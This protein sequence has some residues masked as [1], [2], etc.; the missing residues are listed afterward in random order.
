MDVADDNCD[1]LDPSYLDKL[2]SELGKDN[3]MR[4]VEIVPPHAVDRAA[5]LFHRDGFVAVGNALT[6][7]QLKGARQECEEVANGIFERDPKRIGNRGPYRWSVGASQKTGHLLHIPEVAELVDLPTLTPILKAIFGNDRY[8]CRGARG[9]VNLPGAPYQPLHSDVWKEFLP[10]PSITEWKDS[11][12]LNVRDLP[13]FYVVV[14]FVVHNLTNL[15]APIRQIPMSQ[16]SQ[17]PIP[18]LEDEPLWM[19]RS[20]VCP[21]PAGTAIIRDPRAWHGGTPNLSN[22]M[23]C[24]LNVE[25][26]AYWYRFHTS[27]QMTKSMPRE[28]YSKLSPFA[29]KLC[30]EVVFDPEDK[31]EVGLMDDVT[32]LQGDIIPC[33]RKM[34]LTEDEINEYIKSGRYFSIKHGSS[35]IIR[36]GFYGRMNFTSYKGNDL[37]VKKDEL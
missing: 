9:D 21:A 10:D 3:C 19:K 20:T 14:N 29:Q 31:I 17:R 27:R 7:S 12:R 5:R 13:I 4:E 22:S 11:G 25:Y 8:I 16:Q 28:I 30:R 36:E 34:G 26:Y 35:D 18:L 2:R 37:N 24:L 32:L 15:N 1:Q 33:Y 6:D 23:R